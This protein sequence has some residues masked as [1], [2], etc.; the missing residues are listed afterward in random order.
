M[1]SYGRLRAKELFLKRKKTNL[2]QLY[3]KPVYKF[4]Y[5]YI[6]RLGIL[7]GKKGIVICYLNALS[8]YVRYDELNKINSS[9]KPFQHINV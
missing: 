5:D 6:I 3:L 9:I 4:L 2:I 7:D 1:V 8:V